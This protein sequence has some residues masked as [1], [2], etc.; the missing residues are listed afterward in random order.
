MHLVMF[1]IDG[2]L[3]E[4]NDFDSM[5][6]QEAIQDVLDISV[7]TDWGKYRHVTDSGIVLQTLDELH[8][9][10]ARDPVV[11][12]VKK[13]FIHRVSSYLTNHK[14]SA[15]EGA[16]EFL[17]RLIDREDVKVALATGGWLE[18]AK[19]KLEA[20]GIDVSGAP[21]ASSSDHFS[22]TEIMKI[23]ELRSGRSHYESRTYFGDSP[24][25]L[26][27]SEALGYNFVL[28]GSRLEYDKSVFDFSDS[29]EILA[30]IGLQFWGKS[31][32]FNRSI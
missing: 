15:I 4:S 24:W 10:H 5:C 1:D 25:D 22:R 27:A 3:V 23:A 13:C 2:T 19:L 18:S 32:V 17:S 6:L 31:K 28:V 21:I 20:A 11:E 9:P 12:S 16:P 30:L 14:I 26:R 8:F 7:H 29:N